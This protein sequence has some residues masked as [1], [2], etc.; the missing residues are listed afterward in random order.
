MWKER[1]RSWKKKVIRNT[2]T[3]IKWLY[4]KWRGKKEKGRESKGKNGH[5]QGMPN[6]ITSHVYWWMTFILFSQSQSVSPMHSHRSSWRMFLT[7]TTLPVNLCFH[8]SR[9]FPWVPPWPDFMALLLRVQFPLTWTFVS[10]S[11][12]NQVLLHFYSSSKNSWH[13]QFK[14]EFAPEIGL[15]NHVLSL[16]CRAV[17]C[18]L[19]YSK[20]T[21]TT[22]QLFS[23]DPLSYWKINQNSGFLIFL[24]LPVRLLH[25]P[26]R[27]S[28]IAYY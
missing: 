21:G 13:L 26:F 19:L 24:Q 28:A 15:C 7:Q 8:D 14:L 3:Q 6:P 9:L 23:K 4:K 1:S 20:N 12:L 18:Y 25:C 11:L 22:C 2:G 5:P 17:F 27:R 10:T 16:N